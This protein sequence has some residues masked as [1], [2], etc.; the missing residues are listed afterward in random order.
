MF[1]NTDFEDNE[2]CRFFVFWFCFEYLYYRKHPKIRKMNK[3][4]SSLLKLS[5]SEFNRESDVTIK[6]N[7]DEFL[8]LKYTLLKNLKLPY[9][10]NF[11]RQYYDELELSQ[12]DIQNIIQEEKNK[13]T[14]RFETT[15]GFQAQVNL[16][17]NFRI[18][19]KDGKEFEGIPHEIL[20]D[21]MAI[22]VD[23]ISSTYRAVVINKSFAQFGKD[24]GFIIN[25]CRPYSP[26]TKGKVEGVAKLMDRLKVYNKEFETIEELDEIGYLPVDKDGANL[27][28]QLISKR[29]EENSTIITTNQPFSK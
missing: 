9:D 6:E 29:Y 14:M 21:N 4:S 28:F 5:F 8:Y 10:S 26:Q 11:F 22:V 18:I 24:V 1:L 2:D 13:A 20:F 7:R 25:T 3:N 15:P 17:E 27:V 19:N 23:R 16:K 12:E